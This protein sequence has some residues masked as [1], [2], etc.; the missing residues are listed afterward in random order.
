MKMLVGLMLV[1]FGSFWTGEGLGVHW[2]GADLALPVL[3]GLYAVATWILVRALNAQR[4]RHRAHVEGVAD[5][6]LA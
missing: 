4:T 6:S 3:V 1:S 5:A 2:P